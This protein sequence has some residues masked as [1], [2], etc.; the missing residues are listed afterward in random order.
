MYVMLEKILAPFFPTMTA[1]KPGHVEFLQQPD[2]AMYAYSRCNAS[3]ACLV[4][5]SRT[6]FTA[7]GILLT[8][9]RGS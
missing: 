8:E 9:Y 2:G 5:I 3:K 4:N 6:Q 1:E 7:L